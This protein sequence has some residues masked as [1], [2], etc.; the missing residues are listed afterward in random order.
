M[1]AACERVAAGIGNGVAA[2]LQGVD[3]VAGEMS[4]VAF[5][6][7]FG[8]DGALVPAL[9]I[10][11]TLYIAFF[12]FA[13]LTGRGSL[14]IS[15][16]IPRMMTFGL[17][18]TF[19]TS[20][21]AYQSL[22]WNLAAGA[23]DQ[24]ASIL[25]GTKGSA[26]Q[27]FAQKIDIV[28]GTITNVAGEVGKEPTSVF[29]PGGLLWLGATLLLLGTVGVLV[30]CKI[31]LAVLIALGPVFVVLAL[32]NGTRGLFVGWLKGLTML[33]IAPMFAVLAGSLMLE[34]AVPVIAGLAASPQQ[35]DPRGAMAFF[36]IGAV[37]V[38]LMA[39]VWK[40]A[41]TMV[42]G[43][44]VFGLAGQARQERAA[45]AAASTAA[46]TAAVMATARDAVPYAT[47]AAP[48]AAGIAP[49]RQINLPPVVYGAPAN[50]SGPAHTLGGRRDTHVFA[51]AP[52]GS[53][54]AAGRATSRAR[55]IGSRFKPA[56]P[57][58]MEKLK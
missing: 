29:S 40:T 21:V 13:L 6:R 9:T 25:T 10:L 31:A 47:A 43:W 24:I 51:T 45:S 46:T 48:A 30:T 32:F 39:L 20:W 2:A 57:R 16:L 53:Q 56:P 42:S 38:A 36:L 26:T 23:P 22:V 58:S 41:G 18:L 33:A 54:A 11:L 12:A 52:G 5:G 50:D 37:H 15:S 1:S 34:L 7:L 8:G 27:L 19:V 35:I 4:A 55:G 44:T 14:S 49:T 17:V 28:F 3:C